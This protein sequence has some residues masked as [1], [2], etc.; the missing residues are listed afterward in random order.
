MKT[1]GLVRHGTTEWNLAGRMQGQMDT[2]LAEAGRVQ[3]RL[4]GRRLAS[5][6]GWDGIIASDLSRAAETAQIV[7]AASGIPLIGTDARLRERSFGQIEGT[8]REERIA[9]FGES[10]RELDLGVESDE[11]LLS[12]WDSFLGDAG[13]SHAGRRILIVTHGGYIAPIVQR[14]L[15]R[16]LEENLD[17]T[18]LTVL[19]RDG[20]RW[21]VPLINC[22]EH[23]RELEL[24]Q[25]G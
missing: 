23:L 7:A 14:A 19:D 4:L 12:R 5:E 13:K 9:R 24:S 8:T 15:G 17:N 11:Q 18:S 2:P 10:W 22:T 3:A 6:P 21:N 25:Q 20:E 1:I 16:I